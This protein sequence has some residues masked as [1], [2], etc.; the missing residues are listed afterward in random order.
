MLR[1]ARKSVFFVSPQNN[2]RPT[3]CAGGGCLVSIVDSPWKA[4][5]AYVVGQ[6]I[7]VRHIP[8]GTLH[9]E[10]VITAGT[11]ST[12]PPATWTNTF[13]A[14]VTDGG[15]TWFD[16]GQLTTVPLPTWAANTIYTPPV[17]IVDSN[18]SIEFEVSLAGTSG[19]T[20]PTWATT[21]GAITIDG[22]VQWQ[23][24]GALP[25]AALRGRWRHERRNFRQHCGGGHAGRRFPGLLQ[26][27]W[28]SA[29]RDVRWHGRV[30]RTSFTVGVTIDHLDWVP[31]YAY[32]RDVLRCSANAGDQEAV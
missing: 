12:S 9:T 8:S 6:E 31:H 11:S 15:V 5:T 14:T 26:H 18:G 29:L 21:V 3:A 7:L 27:P 22:G 17:R 4:S 32:E 28:K 23:N 19:G 13:G 30:C 2:G 20:E 25:V 10:V 16:Q 24:A 1:A